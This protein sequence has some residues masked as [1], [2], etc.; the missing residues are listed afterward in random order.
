M[1][2][3]R[4][5]AADG[6]RRGR[7]KEREGLKNYTHT[8]IGDAQAHTHTHTLALAHEPDTNHSL[9][10]ALLLCV[11][12]CPLF[13]VFGRGP[14]VCADLGIPL[15]LIQPFESEQRRQE[16]RQTVEEE[17]GRIDRKKG[18]RL[19]FCQEGGCGGEQSNDCVQAIA[20]NS[21]RLDTASL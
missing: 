9:S 6:L 2:G 21:V 17:K 5:E 12:S 13:R 3:R 8:H 10:A 15:S 11:Q 18:G 19:V 4:T 1:T 16:K 20:L 7:E 14:S